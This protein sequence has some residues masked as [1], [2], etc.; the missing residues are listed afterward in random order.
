MSGKSWKSAIKEWHR[1]VSVRWVYVHM[2]EEYA[3]A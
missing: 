2:I 1:R 3:P